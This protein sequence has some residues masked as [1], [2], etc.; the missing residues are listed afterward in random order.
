MSC[1][2]IR[3]TTYIE[4]LLG[5]LVDLGVTLLADVPLQRDPQL[6]QTAIHSLAQLKIIILYSFQKKITEWEKIVE[7]S[8][9]RKQKIRCVF[10]ICSIQLTELDLLRKKNKNNGEQLFVIMIVRLSRF[11]YENKG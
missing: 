8:Y 10:L 7:L 1:H 11:F 4:G 2:E 5:D 3:G 9:I 6:V